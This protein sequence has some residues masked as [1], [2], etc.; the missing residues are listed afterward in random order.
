MQTIS[1]ILR[2]DHLPELI[3]AVHAR[4]LIVETD[5]SASKEQKA[6]AADLERRVE[7]L[8]DAVT[9]QDEAEAA[10]ATYR[11]LDEDPT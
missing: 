7:L 11:A 1:L 4:A 6:T 8:H 2:A 3:E 10:W 5:L 9:K